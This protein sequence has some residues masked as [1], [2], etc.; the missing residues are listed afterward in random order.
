MCV[1]YTE[2]RDK[3]HGTLST[4]DAVD[5]KIQGQCC[6][7]SCPFILVTTSMVSF[8]CP[9]ASQIKVREVKASLKSC[10]SL[11]RCKREELKRLWL[12]DLKY[13]HMLKMIESM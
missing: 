2:H 13:K 9:P 1:I 8:C 6:T 12:E 3:L 10:K 5:K 7:S 11:L 4:F